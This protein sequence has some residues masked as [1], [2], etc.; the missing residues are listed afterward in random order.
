MVEY[1]KK[2]QGHVEIFEYAEMTI[3]AGICDETHETR[4]V[5]TRS[6][7]GEGE[8]DTECETGGRTQLIIHEREA[9]GGGETDTECETGGRTQLIIH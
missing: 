8:T 7:V 9:N 2:P 3:I 6:G 5:E 1:W 4:R